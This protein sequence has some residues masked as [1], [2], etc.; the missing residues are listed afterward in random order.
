MIC[1]E[2]AY[3]KINLYLKVTGRR[4]DGYH[5]LVT[6][7]QS[8]SLADTLTVERTAGEG[9]ALDCGGALAADDSN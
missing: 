6:V 7:M 9:I 3:A 4:P 5:N 8:V 2:K 1:T